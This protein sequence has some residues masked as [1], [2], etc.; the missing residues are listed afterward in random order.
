MS[1]DLV[2][3]PDWGAPTTGSAGAPA[4]SSLP[5]RSQRSATWDHGRQVID[6]NTLSGLGMPSGVI[7]EWENDPAGARHRLKMVAEAASVVRELGECEAN[8]VIQGFEW[9]PATV[10]TAVLSSWAWEGTA[11]DGPRMTR[12]WPRSVRPRKAR[13]LRDIGVAEPRFMSAVL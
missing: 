4:T 11:A 8:E 9:L 7:A 10:R 12:R 3:R 2:Q 5:A 6:A 13:Y 1:R